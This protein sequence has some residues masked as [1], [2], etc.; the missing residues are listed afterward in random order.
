MNALRTIIMHSQRDFALF[1][2]EIFFIASTE[3]R[4]LPARFPNDLLTTE[5]A[6]SN[7]KSDER[8]S[9]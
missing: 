3:R 9:K 4:G 6:E 1:T 2:V 5:V 7:E 8:L